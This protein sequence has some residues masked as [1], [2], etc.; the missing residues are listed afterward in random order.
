MATVCYA[1]LTGGPSKMNLR[2]N[3][4]G[5]PPLEY[6][7]PAKPRASSFGLFVILLALAVFLLLLYTVALRRAFL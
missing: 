2:T 5:K 7:T 1:A 3:M 4:E 6:E